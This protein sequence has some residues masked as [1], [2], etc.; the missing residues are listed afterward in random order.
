[1]IALV[2]GNYRNQLFW[3]TGLKLVRP[4]VGGFQVFMENISSVLLH[5]WV[6]TLLV[7]LI[8]SIAL[9]MLIAAIV[10]YW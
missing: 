2:P 1:M 6:L 4:K 5:N 9:I 8:F 7:A 3:K 10:A